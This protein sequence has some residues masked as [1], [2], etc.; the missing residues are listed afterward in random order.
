MTSTSGL[1]ADT[2]SIAS[3]FIYD[4]YKV[5]LIRTRLESNYQMCYLQLRLV[6]ESLY[7]H[8]ELRSKVKLLLLTS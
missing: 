1:S 2:I 6:A 5:A 8:R 4:I 3:I 7:Q